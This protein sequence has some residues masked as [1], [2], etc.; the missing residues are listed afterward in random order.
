MYKT[1]QARGNYINPQSNNKSQDSLDELLVS[2][3]LGLDLGVIKLEIRV[4]MNLDKF[5]CLH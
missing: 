1:T 5:S 4:L 2:P 3:D